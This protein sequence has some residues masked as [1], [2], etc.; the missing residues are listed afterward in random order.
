V[1]FFDLETRINPELV[2]W[3]RFAMG[4]SA[5]AVW[6]NTTQWV[7]L[8]DDESIEEAVAHLES[9]DMVV[10]WNGLDFDVP[11]CEAIAGRRLHLRSHWDVYASLSSAVGIRGRRKGMGL[12]PTA[13]RTIALSKL[14]DG[15]HAPELA[16]EGK[17]GRLFNYCSWDVKVLKS[18]VDHLIREGYLVMPGG[19]KVR[20][21]VPAPLR[22]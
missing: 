6:D 9:A 11:V 14:G 21:K 13:E 12:G 10:T 18:L 17:W 22:V 3:D 2:K 19:M 20:V 16:Q 7:H 4:I 15:A 8:Y 5:L 1:V